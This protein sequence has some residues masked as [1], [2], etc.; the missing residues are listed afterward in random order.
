MC[1]WSIVAKKMS[2]RRLPLTSV[3]PRSSTCLPG[4]VHVWANPTVGL[5]PAL[6]C[7][8]GL[9]SANAEWRMWRIVSHLPRSLSP[10][11]AKIQ[12]CKNIVFIPLNCILGWVP[13]DLTQGPRRSLNSTPTCILPEFPNNNSANSHFPFILWSVVTRPEGQDYRPCFWEVGRAKTSPP[14]FLVGKEGAKSEEILLDT[15]QLIPISRPRDVFGF[16]VK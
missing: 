15:T 2:W 11:P 12:T 7:T 4:R 9:I 3:H 16:C 1:K 13:V 6:H 14:I 8:A 5:L 10:G